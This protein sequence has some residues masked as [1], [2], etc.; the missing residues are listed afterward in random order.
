MAKG[1][2]MPPTTA[3]PANPRK[4]G[5]FKNTDNQP[6]TGVY[7]QE[8]IFEKYPTGDLKD[9]I[10]RLYSRVMDD[11]VAI[12]EA[13]LLLKER[14]DR[15]DLE[16]WYAQIGLPSQR[17]SEF[18]RVAKLRRALPAA[19]RERFSALKKSQQIALTRY[20]QK[21]VEQSAANGT[22]VAMA[23]R[24]PKQILEWK[25]GEF[26]RSI[27]HVVEGD[28][29]QQDAAAVE[30]LADEP[31]E[32]HALSLARDEIIANVLA[33]QVA[34]GR[35]LRMVRELF[36]ARDNDIEPDRI[37]LAQCLLRLL[38][39]VEEDAQAIETE[40]AHR[41]GVSLQ[42]PLQVKQEALMPSALDAQRQISTEVA[43]LQLAVRS[44]LR[45]ART[46]KR[47]APTKTLDTA[48]AQA[49]KLDKPTVK[50][51]RSAQP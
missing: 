18:T 27:A 32:P 17:V 42:V 36:A 33:A 1:E 31:Q 15:G 37:Q 11:I 4:S 5:D 16:A 45:K 48:I 41:F 20:T 50:E 21:E 19:L 8:K 40:L 2:L 14:A 9:H 30:A 28:A 51:E 35:T 10:A 12:G 3:E 29:A 43:D 49:L 25:Q 22:L 47:G 44:K 13:L 46:P 7:C 23:Q 6:L 26:K 39:P 24:T 38:Q 34:V